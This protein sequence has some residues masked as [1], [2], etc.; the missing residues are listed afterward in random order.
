MAAP[1]LVRVLLPLLAFFGP[2]AIASWSAIDEPLYRSSTSVLGLFGSALP[3]TGLPGLLLARTLT[4]LPI[5]TETAR[6]SLLPPLALALSSLLVFEMAL[7]K[8]GA[9]ARGAPES[10]FFAL[11][12]SLGLIGSL[13][14]L[15]ESLVLG[16]GALGAALGLFALYLVDRRAKAHTGSA[17][18]E[19]SMW[20][21]F[22]GLLGI[23]ALESPYVAVALLVSLGAEWCLAYL[24]GAPHRLN[25]TKAGSFF[26]GVAFPP[27][28]LHFARL[29]RG[30][31]AASGS[32][33][34]W[35]PW[36]GSQ[37]LGQIGWFS[38]LLA[39]IGIISLL[40]PA[41][42]Q[43]R[44]GDLA[45]ES[46]FLLISIVLC[47]LTF[48]G[49]L[50][51][52][53]LADSSMAPR[54]ALHLLALAALAILGALGLSFLLRLARS[55][56]LPAI[57]GAT[58]LSSVLSVSTSLSL[59]ERSLA[60]LSQLPVS[61]P[62]IVLEQSLT[63][64]P[65]NSLLLLAADPLLPYLRAAQARGAR[66]DVMITSTSQLA[67][68]T[69]MRRAKTAEPRIEQLIVDLNVQGLPSEHALNLLADERPVYAEVDA[70]W[71]RAAL[72]H[73]APYALV[74]EFR[75]HSLGRSERK[76]AHEAGEA[77]AR[78]LLSATENATSADETTRALI[79][80]HNEELARALERCQDKKMASAVRD[81]YGLQKAEGEN[82]TAEPR[83]AD[84]PPSEQRRASF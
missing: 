22:G 36:S 71:D 54:S 29:D 51:T 12:A 67:K 57:S 59:A 82:P 27:A 77:R 20:L 8:L 9:R 47:D 74:A 13:P 80:Q 24:G 58:A 42:T 50:S 79:R 62:G 49:T 46:P 5:G 11:S 73:L 41:S 31:A 81:H 78:A 43:V 55:T 68:P 75:P 18:A 53:L 83:G 52:N 69:E 76:A 39:S 72:E 84:G 40:T 30:E 32:L 16:G 6:A 70:R 7:D 28:C 64:L 48:P 44:R 25:W 65:R 56:R 45:A 3:E 35:F 17:K 2:L 66:P 61:A 23:V 19:L 14:W 37:Y 38:A 63:T 15:G 34:P 1:S 4:F 60:F 26:L 33:G 10:R 21:A